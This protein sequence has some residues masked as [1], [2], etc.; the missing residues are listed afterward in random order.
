MLGQQTIHEFGNP[1]KTGC[2]D[3]WEALNAM[4]MRTFSLRSL[5]YSRTRSNPDSVMYLAV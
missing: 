5:E 4:V 3:I 1:W 2:L